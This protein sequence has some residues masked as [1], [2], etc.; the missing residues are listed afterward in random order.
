MHRDLGRIDERLALEPVDARELVLHLGVAHRAI[1]RVFELHA[2]AVGPAVVDGEDDPAL[3]DQGLVKR[4]LAVPGVGHLLPVRAAIDIEIDRIALAG[5]E[6]GRE[7][8]VVE[9]RSVGPGQQPN[10]GSTWLSR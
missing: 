10:V 6:L 7:H 4:Q 1:D 9:F 3:V 2:A 5:L 8:P